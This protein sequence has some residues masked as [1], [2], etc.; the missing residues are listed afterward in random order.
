MPTSCYILCATQRTGS[1][2]LCEALWA[3]GV[4]G[5]PMEHFLSFGE[6][7]ASTHSAE[8]LASVYVEGSSAN[9]VFGT[10]VMANYFATLVEHLRAIGGDA[11]T[12]QLLSEFFPNLRYVYVSRQDKVRQAVSLE[13]AIQSNQW[14]LDDGRFSEMVIR[15][16]PS[17]I[18]AWYRDFEAR[19]EQQRS[20]E[21]TPLR[22]DFNK[23]LARYEEIVR[24]DK[25]WTDY[26]K[27][28]GVKP[29]EIVYENL[30]TNKPRVLSALLDYLEL[31]AIDSSAVESQSLQ[32]QHD[33]INDEWAERF[34]RDLAAQA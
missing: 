4:A 23:L 33:A 15:G 13:K 34:R 1:N 27:A 6:L 17:T 11:P 18:G 3:T 30:A 8:R 28:A 19:L 9:G 24:G 22:Y 25:I 29:F 21:K 2:L 26:F 5:R 31:P 7:I 12:G 16:A 10:K 14:V 32:R 20:A